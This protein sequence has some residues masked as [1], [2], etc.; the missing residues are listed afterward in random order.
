M[1]AS[2]NFTK[3][4][5]KKK[6]NS[7]LVETIALALKN[8]PWNALAHKLSGSTR[9]F[10]AVNLSQIDK[11]TTPGDTIVVP[12]KV[13]SK[14][15]ITKKVRVCALGFSEAAIEKLKQTKS[16][17]VSIADEIKKNPKFTGV[18]IIK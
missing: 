11:A 8:K 18:K 12:G 15:E 7:V 17:I 13:L 3:K 1:R 2:K 6:T 9:N 5:T 14:G 16:E 10:S 4:R